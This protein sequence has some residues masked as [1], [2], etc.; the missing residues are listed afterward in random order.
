MMQGAAQKHALNQDQAMVAR[1]RGIAHRLIPQTAAFRAD[2]PRWKWEVNLL[3]SN[4]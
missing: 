2:A 1:V 4:K 3:T